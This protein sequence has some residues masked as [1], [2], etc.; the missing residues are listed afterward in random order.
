MAGG[1]SGPEALTLLLRLLM[2]HS[3]G[4]DTEEGYTKLQTFGMC[5]GTPF[6]DFSPEFR[7]L[8]SIATWSERVCLRARM[9]CW[10]WFGWR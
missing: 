5:N 9:W 2:T 10:R 7:V 6:S 8:V 4:V 3:D 1:A